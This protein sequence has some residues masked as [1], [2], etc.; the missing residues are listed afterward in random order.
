MASNTNFN[1]EAVHGLMN[2]L[3]QHCENMNEAQYMNMCNAL[4]HLH[5]N[6]AA[7]ICTLRQRTQVVREELDELYERFDFQRHEINERD[8]RLQE[9]DQRLQEQDQRL[10]EQDQRLQEQDQRLKE[11]DQMNQP[12]VET[13]PIIPELQREQMK[14]QR[15]VEEKEQKRKQSIEHHLAKL[16]CFQ[17]KL[18]HLKVPPNSVGRNHKTLIAKCSVLGITISE[19]LQKA[20]ST[21]VR[22]LQELVKENNVDDAEIKKLYLQDRHIEFNAEKLKL[23][24][25]IQQHKDKLFMLQKQ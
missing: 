21:S 20:S 22:I 25:L 16:E 12:I 3:D 11:Y 10:Q 24:D 8:Q 9:Q 1:S 17:S 4:R 18:R 14:E 7:K 15:S 23:H 2:L 6:D 5:I 13:L 19:P